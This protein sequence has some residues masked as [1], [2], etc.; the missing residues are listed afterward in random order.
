MT[1]LCFGLFLG[2]A[3]GSEMEADTHEVPEN[4]IF[5]DR[6]LLG[7]K[8]RSQSGVT[9]ASV[10]GWTILQEAWLLSGIRRLELT[11]LSL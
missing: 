10:E 2:S 7:G 11:E 3:W 9:A 8:M 6:Q 1:R 5:V 4:G